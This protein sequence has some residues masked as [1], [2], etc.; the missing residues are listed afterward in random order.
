MSW[1]G[2][3]PGNTYVTSPELNTQVEPFI[4]LRES[5][6]AI[7]SIRYSGIIAAIGIVK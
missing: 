7:L 2:R 3:A 6:D 1:V 5:I 4:I